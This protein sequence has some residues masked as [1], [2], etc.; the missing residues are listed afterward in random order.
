MNDKENEMQNCDEPN[1][2]LRED[3]KFLSYAVT[4]NWGE[5]GMDAAGWQIL[6]DAAEHL[7]DRCD[8]L[9]IFAMAR[10][11][12]VTHRLRGEIQ[13]AQEWEK[14]AEI[15]RRDLPSAWRG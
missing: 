2:T 15:A 3:G 11:R 9:S 8:L 5:D 4:P 13:D 6:Q 1:L 10:R 7:R 14:A 12:A